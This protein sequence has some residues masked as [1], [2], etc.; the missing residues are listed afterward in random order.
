MNPSSRPSIADQLL[1]DLKQESELVNLII[2]G[3]IEDRWAIAPEEQEIARAIIYNAFETYAV[4]RGMPLEQAEEFCEQH[5]EQLI[6]TVQ[7]VL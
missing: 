4:S 7:A 5:L 1:A 3:C 6:E 2:Q